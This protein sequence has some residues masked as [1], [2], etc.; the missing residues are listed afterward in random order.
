M[1]TI[2]LPIEF[3]EFLQL[4][5][6]NGVEYLL[7]GGFSVG[8]YGYPR[9]TGDIDVWINTSKENAANVTKALVEFGFDEANVNPQSF[10]RKN[11]VFRM[12]VPPLQID[13]LTDVSGVAFKACYKKRV[14]AEID[15][16]QVS[17]ISL[18]HL[19][20]NKRASGRHKDLDDLEH[21]PDE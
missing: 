12:G 1:A 19:K 6:S 15:G 8:Y 7:V 5:N 18:V 3:K 11:K 4:L 13:I 20:Q 16:I 21:L 17:V 2:Q 9:A 14:I 10:R